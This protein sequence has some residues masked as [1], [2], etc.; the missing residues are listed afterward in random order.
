VRTAIGFYADN[1]VW[2]QRWK[3]WTNMV[4]R[5]CGFIG[6][7]MSRLMMKTMKSVVMLSSILNDNEVEEKS[8]VNREWK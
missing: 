8:K 2:R 7:I 5:W 6:Q 3:T 4:E 1:R